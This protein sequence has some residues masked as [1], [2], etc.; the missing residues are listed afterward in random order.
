MKKI[1]TILVVVVVLAG[2]YLIY[3]PF[4]IKPLMV[5]DITDVESSNPVVA[6]GVSFE[7]T[8][9]N[10]QPL[11]YLN[12]NHGEGWKD[13]DRYVDGKRRPLVVTLSNQQ[14]PIPTQELTIKDKGRAF[15]VYLPSLSG[16]GGSWAWFY[17]GSDGSSYWGCEASETCDGGVRGSKRALRK[18]NLARKAVPIEVQPR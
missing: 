3:D 1:L 10:V 17:I 7:D 2:G 6:T 16:Q 11:G 8:V 9:A 18:E 4:K 12:W 14:G 5:E 13:D 15:K